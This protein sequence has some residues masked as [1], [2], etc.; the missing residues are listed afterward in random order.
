[1]TAFNSLVDEYGATLNLAWKHHC[2]A[3]F[4]NKVN[5]YQ[6]DDQCEVHRVGNSILN[7]ER[8]L[9]QDEA[10]S[11]DLKRKLDK[12]EQKFFKLLKEGYSEQQKYASE[13]LKR[14]GQILEK[15]LL[16]KHKQAEFASCA[17]VYIFFSDFAKKNLFSP[18]AS[19]TLHSQEQLRRDLLDFAEIL[20]DDRD[21]DEGPSLLKF[22]FL[23]QLKKKGKGVNEIVR[24]LEVLAL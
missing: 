22:F 11:P 19:L 4:A 16:S 20:Y 3:S 24:F 8:R 14:I 23:C 13:L 7:T 1:M 18:E 10:F 2:R 15:H 5:V 17:S 9:A 12:L 21:E 6:E